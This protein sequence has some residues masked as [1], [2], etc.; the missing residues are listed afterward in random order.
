MDNLETLTPL[1]TQ[2]VDK[3]NTKIQHRTLKRKHGPHLKPGVITV[4]RDW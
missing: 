3:Q 2:D 4:A 1:G